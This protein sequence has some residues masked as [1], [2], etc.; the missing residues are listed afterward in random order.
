MVRSTLCDQYRNTSLEKGSQYFCLW[1]SSSLSERVE[2]AFLL[3]LD[4]SGDTF[5]WVETGSITDR[6][7]W[8]GGV[9]DDNVGMVGRSVQI[10]ILTCQ[11][12]PKQKLHSQPRPNDP[13]NLICPQLLTTLQALGTLSNG[14]RFLVPPVRSQLLWHPHYPLTTHPSQI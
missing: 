9:D 1:A 7:E 12:H 5:V 3:G 8:M 4:P 11:H 2:K 6:C 14:E 13:Q 10:C